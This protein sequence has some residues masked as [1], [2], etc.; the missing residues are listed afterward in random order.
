[1]QNCAKPTVSSQ[2]ML[3]TVTVSRRMDDSF[4][5]RTA[6]DREFTLHVKPFRLWDTC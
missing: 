2:G 6:K 1:M 3:T 4:C 5:R